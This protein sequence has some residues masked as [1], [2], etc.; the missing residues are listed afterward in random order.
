MIK[1]TKRDGSLEPIDISKIHRAVEWACEGLGVDVSQIETDAHI[2]FY[3]GIKTE[4][5]QRLLIFSAASLT[6]VDKPDYEF[7]AARLLLQQLYRTSGKFEHYPSLRKVVTNLVTSNRLSA[8]LSFFNFDALEA[9]ISPER[10]FKFKY[11]GLQT[12]ADRYLLEGEL[13][14]HFWM[15]VAMGIALAEEPSTRT[16]WAIKFY[17]VMSKFEY[18][19]STPT[20]FNAG[21]L[22]PQLSSCFV[23]T[24]DDSIWEP[25]EGVSLGKGIFASIAEAALYSKFSGGLGIDVSRIRA[26]GAPI[27]STH[28]ESSGVVPY[29]KIMND[30]ALAVNQG[31]K[32]NGSFAVYLQPWHADVERF[33]DL[34]KPSGDERLRAREIF[35]YL[36]VCDIFMERV[37]DDEMW[38]L[39]C[40][41]VVPELNDLHGDAFKI[42]YLKAEVEGKATKVV[43][44][45]A[46]W[47]SIISNLAGDSGTPMITFKD[48]S[49]R[50]NPQ[51]HIGTVKSSNLCG[52][53]IEVS[54]DTESAVCNLGSIV[55]PNVGVADLSRV[56]PLAMRMLD[57]V[58]DTNFYPTDKINKSNKTH[59]PVGL[60]VMGWT[61]M[62][63]V[64]GVDFESQQHLDFNA[65][66]FEALSIATIKASVSLAQERGAYASY[67]GSKWS[68]GILP[69]DT[70]KDE[71]LK[72]VEGFLSPKW[73]E[74]RELVAQYGVRNS[75]MLAIAPT[76]TIANIAGTQKSTEPS[77]ASL[78]IKDNKSGKFKVVDPCVSHAANVK[79]AF[80]IDQEWLI[81]AAA[82]RQCFIDQAQSLNLF[83]ALGTKGQTISGWYFLAWELGL[84]TTYYLYQQQE[85]VGKACLLTDPTCQSCQ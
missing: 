74:V 49:N 16:Y 35:P 66:Y 40:P 62:L 83:K 8:E 51:D 31:G 68:R 37:R 52:E 25:Q 82:V 38:S 5:V 64:K 10:D 63:A 56:V 15:R 59:R 19:P 20:L 76:A 77:F 75:N 61:E 73:D 17:D 3:E 34:T 39:F 11:L 22:Y 47:R 9:A 55:A 26:S 33:I 80:E 85:E 48:E 60:G 65:E 50:R 23:I 43:P 42:A 1:V 21:T 84:K 2:Q 14:Q 24:V 18:I 29:I 27:N 13:P 78:Y 44:A 41:S 6:T 32:R 79:T 30:T 81:K 67:A 7:A 12:L 36:W 53:I 45:K 54:N 57:N 4:D 71:A 70:C 72:L 46:L 69:I 28:G 58:I